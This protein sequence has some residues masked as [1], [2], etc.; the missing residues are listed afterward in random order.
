MKTLFAFNEKFAVSA[1]EILSSEELV[2]V[3]GGHGPGEED[4]YWEDEYNK[5]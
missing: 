4:L 3:K 2:L 5:K 1:I